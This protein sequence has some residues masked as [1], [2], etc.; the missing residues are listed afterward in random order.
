MPPLPLVEHVDA[1]GR[2]LLAL[3]DAFL[4]RQVHETFTRYALGQRKK[5]EVDIRTHG[6]PVG[7]TRC[8]S[9]ASSPAPATCS[10]RAP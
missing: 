9:S 4:S 1:T 5:L 7:N 3:R 8:T 6:A 2:E 10:A